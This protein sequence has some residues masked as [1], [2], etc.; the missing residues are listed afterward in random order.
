M[1]HL[2]RRLIIALVLLT[3][4]L[5]SGV[6]IASTVVPEPCDTDTDTSCGCDL[7]CLGD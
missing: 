4:L 1:T 7:D 5:V 2:T 3:L 6:L